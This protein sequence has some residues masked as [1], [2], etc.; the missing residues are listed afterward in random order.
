MGWEITMRAS[1][2]LL[3]LALL[4]AATF[5][6]EVPTSS[7]ELTVG[8]RV[9]APFVIEDVAS[10]SYSG[11]AADL[12]SEIAA[13]R[14]YQVRYVE[15]GLPEL[16]NAVAS[17]EVDVAL[18]ALTVTAE[19]AQQMDFTHP[20]HSTG[21]AIAVHASDSAWLSVVQ[22]LVSWEFLRVLGALTLILAV[23]GV[24]V[25]AM[26]RR[27]NPEQFGGPTASGVGQGFWWAAVT[28][29][30]VGY[31]DKSPITLGGR[32]IALVWMFVGIILISSFTAA[33]TSSLTVGA[34]SGR[35]QSP[36]DLPG[37]RVGTLADSTS[38][39]WLSGLGM[40]SESFP[41]ID[42]ALDAL[43]DGTLDAVVYDAPLL[44]HNLRN[45]PGE[46][47][48]LLPSRPQRQ[49]YA[50]ALRPGSDLRSE[51]NLSLLQLLEQPE[52]REGLRRYLGED[53]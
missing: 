3:V 43:A 26:E 17:G 46:G 2:A 40:V 25:W 27:R 10:G 23:F 35:I 14:G 16:L 30:T 41:D 8:V 4:S 45:R 38:A 28:M 33:I 29:T 20:F 12:W 47:L 34:L 53:Y 39:Q 21:L 11:L 24:L 13:E 1:L 6:Q 50:L 36:Q 52:W 31:G 7:T 9:G 18:G 5:A 51:I 42:A 32:L 19:R 22:A 49:D 44:Q 48:T 15:M 37:T